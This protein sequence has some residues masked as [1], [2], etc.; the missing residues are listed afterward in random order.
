[1]GEGTDIVEATRVVEKS[2]Q[3]QRPMRYEKA[4]TFSCRCCKDM[5]RPANPVPTGL[6]SSADVCGN[7]RSWHGV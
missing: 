7:I 2:R 4:G 3:S 1:M 5:P 6:R